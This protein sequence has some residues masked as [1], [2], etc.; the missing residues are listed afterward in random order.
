MK[1]LFE[2]R[3]FYTFIASQILMQDTS[4]FVCI[5]KRQN[6]ECYRLTLYSYNRMSIW[7]RCTQIHSKRTRYLFA[8]H[9]LYLL[10]GAFTML[11][12]VWRTDLNV[13]FTPRVDK[14]R[15]FNNKKTNL[16]D[17]NHFIVFMWF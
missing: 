6:I 7:N 9:K 2:R 4:R 5:V 14:S 12:R 11:Q 1:F 16:D 8:F 17:S 3:Q 10:T 13:A 15:N